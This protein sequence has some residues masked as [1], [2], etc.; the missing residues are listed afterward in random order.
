MLFRTVPLIAGLLTAACSIPE[1]A[2]RVDEI[3]PQSSEASV[4]RPQPTLV[5]TQILMQTAEA[6][7][8]QIK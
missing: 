3:D 6:V 8:G 1:D 4:D 2:P 7:R 5:E